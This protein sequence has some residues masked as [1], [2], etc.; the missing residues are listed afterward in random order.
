MKLNDS[1]VADLE[2]PAGETKT[3]K[4]ITDFIYFDDAV[5]GLGVRLRA[6]CQA[7]WIF[8]YRVGPKQRR[9]QLGP[10]KKLGADDARKHAK[11]LLARVTLGEDPQA[12]KAK[13]KATAACRFAAV[14]EAYVAHKAQA[15]KLGKLRPR[16]L[17]GIEHYLRKSWSPLHRFEVDA[18][19]LHNVAAVLKKIAAESGGTAAARARSTLQGMYRWAM[20]EGVAKKNP[21]IG[22][23]VPQEAAPR[24]RVLDAGEIADVWRACRDD[25]HGRIIRLLLLTGARRAEIGSLKWSEV[26]LEHAVVRLPPERVKNKRPF[27]I[28]LAPLAL[29]IIESVPRRVDRDW[30][31]GHGQGFTGWHMARLALAERVEA[32]RAK[33]GLAPMKAWR[34]HDLRRSAATGM[35]DIGVAPHIIEAALNHV[36]GHK[37]GVAG[38]YNRSSYGKEVKLALAMWAERVREITEGRR[39]NRRDVQETSLSAVDASWKCVLD[40]DSARELVAA[41][42]RKLPG[43]REPRS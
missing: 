36:S 30:L 31:F 14:V 38:V 3:G 2:L 13:A 42:V 28:P 34:T 23:N 1:I 12:E 5:A 25:D 11:K 22:T 41:E 10:V 4:P 26:D 35:A 33:A 40:A 8:Q 24:D 39:A 37:A 21:V 19:E 15:V 27:V 6:G 18:V 7:I 9:M 29:Q 16:S 32:R 43:D 17:D 20:G